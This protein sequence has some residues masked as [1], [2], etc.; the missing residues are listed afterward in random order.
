MCQ[1][2]DEGA[3]YSP[4]QAF[5]S[6]MPFLPRPILLIAVLIIFFSTYFSNCFNVG[7]VAR[8]VGE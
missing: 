5:H 3:S 8:I 2:S 7:V 6:C 1:C 4:V